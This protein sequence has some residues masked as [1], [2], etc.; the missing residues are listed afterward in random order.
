MVLVVQV[1]ALFLGRSHPHARMPPTAELLECAKHLARH[2]RDA[3]RD[4]AS[5]M[6]WMAGRQPRS[7]GEMELWLR[8]MTDPTAERPTRRLPWGEDQYTNIGALS[9]QF[10]EIFFRGPLISKVGAFVS[11]QSRALGSGLDTIDLRVARLRVDVIAAKSSAKHSDPHMLV[12]CMAPLD[13]EL[14]H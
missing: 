12:R 2:A 5:A 7:F 11:C 3:V 14:C 1:Y 9:S 4:A 6:R 8:W 13:I 10:F